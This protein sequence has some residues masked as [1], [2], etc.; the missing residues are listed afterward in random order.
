[1]TGRGSEPVDQKKQSATDMDIDYEVVDEPDEQEDAPQDIFER[2]DLYAS[3]DD[4]EDDTDDELEQ[5]F[6]LGAHMYQATTLMSD[7]HIPEEGVDRNHATAVQRQVIKVL[8]YH[9]TGVSCDR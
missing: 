9:A 3:D 7:E 2:D 1:M 4:S 5:Q 8:D 6:A